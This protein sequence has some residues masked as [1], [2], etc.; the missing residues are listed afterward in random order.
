M[1]FVLL[2]TPQ[3][4]KYYVIVVEVFRKTF[5]VIIQTSFSSSSRSLRGA[6][7]RCLSEKR[8]PCKGMCLYMLI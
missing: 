1:R 6:V 5:T 8:L 4:L 3:L 7:F 2:P